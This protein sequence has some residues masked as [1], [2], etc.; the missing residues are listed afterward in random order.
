LTTQPDI[1]AILDEVF[2]KLKVGERLQAHAKEQREA[3]IESRKRFYTKEE[4]D[5]LKDAFARGLSIGQAAAK[6]GRSYHS[7]YQWA[8]RNAHHKPPGYGT[9]PIFS[10]DSEET[11]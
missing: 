11:P 6:I 9:A 3:I 10:P 8:K 4:I 5:I 2:A 1:E 7:V